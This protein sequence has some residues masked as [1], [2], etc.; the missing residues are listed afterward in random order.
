VGQ[1][2][3]R[4]RYFDLALKRE[5]EETQRVALKRGVKGNLSQDAEV[6]KNFTIAN[7]AQALSTMQQSWKRNDLQSAENAIRTAVRQTLDRYPEVE[8]ADIRA[9][10]EVAQNYLSTLEKFNRRNH[11]LD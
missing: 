3:V 5:V 10:F 4:L 11:V 9:Q 7:I 8:D 2:S 6:L 1:V